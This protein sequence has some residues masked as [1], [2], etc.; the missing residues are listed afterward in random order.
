M[1]VT[2]L[3]MGLGGRGDISCTEATHEGDSGSCCLCW[4]HPEV[5]GC[6][7]TAKGNF[8]MWN[9]GPSKI[10][11]TLSGQITRIYLWAKNWCLLSC[12]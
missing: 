6:G 10:G 7:A 11:S 1:G 2:W 9:P 3:G 4:A 12:K 5:Q 8:P